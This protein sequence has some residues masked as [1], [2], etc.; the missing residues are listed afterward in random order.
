[1]AKPATIANIASNQPLAAC[2]AGLRVFHLLNPTSPTDDCPLSCNLASTGVL[3]QPR[4]VLYSKVN[5]VQRDLKSKVEC[6]SQRAFHAFKTK[7]W[8]KHCVSYRKADT[9]NHPTNESKPHWGRLMAILSRSTL[10]A[11]AEIA[12]PSKAH[13]CKAPKLETTKAS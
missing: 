1:M 9:S 6:I 4:A 2:L 5:K 11:I 10:D 12:E 3:E 8:T 13:S 7:L